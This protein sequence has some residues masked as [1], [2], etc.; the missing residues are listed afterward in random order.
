LLALWTAQTDVGETR[1][2]FRNNNQKQKQNKHLEKSDKVRN[3]RTRKDLHAKSL[4]D[5]AK[6]PISFPLAVVCALWSVKSFPEFFVL[7]D[8]VLRWDE[9]HDEDRDN[10]DDGHRRRYACDAYC[11]ESKAK[12]KGRS[13]DSRHD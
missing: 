1:E 11:S 4:T 12:E 8:G 10:D 3:K 2:S 13:L 9:W 7:F 5:D 6:N